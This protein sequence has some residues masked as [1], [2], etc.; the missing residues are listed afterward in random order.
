MN[1][2][3]FMLI[4]ILVLLVC[5]LTLITD[6]FLLPINEKLTASISTFASLLA[7]V[8]VIVSLR[9]LQKTEEILK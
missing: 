6:I 9:S 1:D 4:I 2:R 7:G 8:T 3:R 5:F